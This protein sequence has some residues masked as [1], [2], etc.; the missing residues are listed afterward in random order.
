MK[1]LG[2]EDYHDILDDIEVY[3]KEPY[4]KA[5]S[6]VDRYLEC[7]SKYYELGLETGKKLRDF[8]P[9]RIVYLGIGG[10]AIAGD[11]IQTIAR[12]ITVKVHRDYTVFRSDPDD[13]IIAVSYS[14]DTAEIFPTILD[15]L[16]SNRR[17][18][19]IT[20]D[21]RLK[22]LAE[23]KN[24]PIIVLEH[25]MPPRYSF[26]HTLGALFGLLQCL[27]I[28]I[29]ALSE[30]IEEA[31][32]TK[33]NISIEVP[34]TMNLAKN[35][36]SRIVDK[37]P[38]V[39]GYGRAVPIAYRLKCQLNENSKMF[40]HF[41]EV[42]EAL[43][44]DVEI[45]NEKTILLAPRLSE[46]PR[47]INEVYR[48]LSS[49]LGE[50]YIELKVQAKNIMGE[51]LSLLIL[52]DYISLY[53]AMIRNVDPLALYVIPKLKD[54]NRNYQEILRSVDEKLGKI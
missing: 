34:T 14:G 51:I 21:G 36:A 41:C 44:N 39:Y 28:K 18:V 42:P 47:E 38:I 2:K 20:S 40:S 10:S 4:K 53:A 11:F 32:K 7:F 8:K 16:E 27:G 15:N 6:L 22:K 45:L 31:E 50:N 24:L 3:R 13:L 26:P 52:V 12:D 19:M 54:G 48:V 5:F 35:S 17:M 29:E 46:E 25:G 1:E 43:H 33:A 9:S 30:S 49:F 37:L 23:K